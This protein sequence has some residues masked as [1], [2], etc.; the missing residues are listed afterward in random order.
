M[1]SFNDIQTLWQNQ[2][3]AHL[4]D[5]ETVKKAANKIRRQI[6]IKNLMSLLSLCATVV[7]IAYI[8]VVADFK[9][10]TTKLGIIVII[11]A[12]LGG[13]VL[14]SQL[15]KILFNAGNSA[16]SNQAYLQQLINFRNKQRFFQTKGMVA[17]FGLLTFGFTLYLYEFYA[18]NANFGL[19]A[20]ALTMLWIAFAWFYIRPRVIRKQ[21]KKITDLINQIESI[22]QQLEN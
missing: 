6:I 12:I 7:F 14:N 13:I 17:Y 3:G 20:Y 22:S 18:R 16:M 10:I 1:D 9:Y 11:I 2:P 19:S 15:L 4:P 8:G 21:D 5:A